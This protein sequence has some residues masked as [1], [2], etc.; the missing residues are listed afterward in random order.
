MK[1]AA[2]SKVPQ[3]L[4]KAQEVCNWTALTLAVAKG[5]L[6]KVQELA[7]QGVDL[8]AMDVSGRSLTYIAEA[9]GQ[10]SMA[11]YLLS[12]GV[13]NKKDRRGGIS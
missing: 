10:S 5:D 12:K 2:K 13:E 6:E 9:Y 11:Q 4:R 3:E 1:S 7:K 8:K